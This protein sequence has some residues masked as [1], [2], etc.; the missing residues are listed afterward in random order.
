MGT[1]IQVKKTS[2]NSKISTA[3]I[4]YIELLSP[5]FLALFYPRILL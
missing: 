3:A 5:R 4:A 2:E 1:E